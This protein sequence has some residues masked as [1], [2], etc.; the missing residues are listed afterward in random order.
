M[1]ATLATSFMVTQTR[2]TSSML[3]PAVL[4]VNLDADTWVEGAP[5]RLA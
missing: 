3:E 2:L 5:H 1:K 4:L